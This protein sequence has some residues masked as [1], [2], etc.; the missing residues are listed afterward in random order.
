MFLRFSVLTFLLALLALPAQAGGGDDDPPH[1]AASLRASLLYGGEAAHEAPLRVSGGRSVPLAFGLSAAVPGLGQAYN[2]QWAKAALALGAEV[3]L[4]AGHR[5]WT[6]RGKDGRDAYQAYA[7]QFWS[8]VQYARWLNDYKTWLVTE[9]STSV[10]APDVV[11]DPALN[12]IDLTNPAGWTSAET[13]TVRGLIEQIRRLEDDVIHPET[14]A[15]FSHKLPFFGEQQYYE[16][17]GKYFQFAPGWEDY[18]FVRDA[19][20]NP[21]WIDADGNFIESIDP[22]K[23]GPNNAKPNVSTR[24]LDY[25]E[26]HGAANDYLRRASR[27][28][29]FFLANH[30]LAAVDAAIFAKVHNDRLAARLDLTYDALGEPVPGATV[31]VR[32]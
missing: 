6:R 17:V 24:F 2:R 31:S 27:L 28:T 30:F 8:P 1:T 15:S 26:D 23:S 10:T 13:Q 9:L 3:A 29:A 11:I 14:G 21:T 22:E 32:F 19:D 18:Q 16:L 12:S 4:V 25:A 20:G 7:H 5:T